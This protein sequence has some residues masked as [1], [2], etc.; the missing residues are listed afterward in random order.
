MLFIAYPMQA[1]SLWAQLEALIRIYII[2]LFHAEYELAL[3]PV[4]KRDTAYIGNTELAQSAAQRSVKT[5][6]GTVPAAEFILE[7]LDTEEIIGNS[8]ASGKENTVS[9][10]L[11]RLTYL[12]KTYPLEDIT[13][14]MCNNETVYILALDNAAIE[15]LFAQTTGFACDSNADD[16]VYIKADYHSKHIEHDGACH[17][18]TVTETAGLMNTVNVDDTTCIKAENLSKHFK[19]DEACHKEPVTEA[20]N[21]TDTVNVDDAACIKADGLDSLAKHGGVYREEPLIKALDSTDA[22]YMDVAACT[23]ADSPS[24]HSEHNQNYYEEPVTEAIQFVDTDVPAVE[25]ADC[26]KAVDS[27]SE[28]SLSGI[29]QGKQPLNNTS[30]S[31]TDKAACHKKRQY[32]ARSPLQKTKAKVLPKQNTSALLAGTSAGASAARRPQRTATATAATTPAYAR[33]TTSSLLK[34]SR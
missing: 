21:S 33:G 14:L 23:K 5:S 19:R 12:Y 10:D 30:G 20:A 31:G 27:L 13:R 24:K 15:D 32:P 22:V 2:A 25:S 3:T 16:A 4:E 17:N 8:V 26:I 11:E 1:L 6:T 18:E 29:A 28:H 7:H 34:R 9:L